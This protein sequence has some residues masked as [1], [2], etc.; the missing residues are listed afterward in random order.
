[1]KG[2]DVRGS[3]YVCPLSRPPDNTDIALAVNPAKYALGKNEMTFV[4]CTRIKGETGH[5]PFISII[6]RAINASSK[7]SSKIGSFKLYPN[8]SQSSS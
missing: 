2:M 8:K 3:E 4:G 1:M 7:N 6:H 5:E